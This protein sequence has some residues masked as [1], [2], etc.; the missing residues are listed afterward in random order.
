MIV[1][2]NRRGQPANRLPLVLVFGGVACATLARAMLS[3]V[4]DGVA[5]DVLVVA[6]LLGFVAIIV[7]GTAGAIVVVVARRRERAGR[8]VRCG[9][10]LCRFP[11]CSECGGQPAGGMVD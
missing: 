5:S 1:R 2:L 8:C 11:R 6:T 10:P 9:H 4:G 3:V 7:G